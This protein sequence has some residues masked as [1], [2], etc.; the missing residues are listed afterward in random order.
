M[1]SNNIHNGHRNIDIC[2]SSSTS[3][4]MPSATEQLLQMLQRVTG[5][6]TPPPASLSSSQPSQLLGSST[7]SAGVL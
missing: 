4:Q 1:T 7:H 6:S 3:I 5:D 2:G